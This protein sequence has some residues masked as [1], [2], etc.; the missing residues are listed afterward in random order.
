MLVRDGRN[1]DP[2]HVRDGR[3]DERRHD[4]RVAVDE[5]NRHQVSIAFAVWTSARRDASIPARNQHGDAIMKKFSVL[6]I[7]GGAALLTAVPFSLQWSQEKN[8]AVTL[9]SADA[10][11][12]QPLSAGSV[13]GVKRREGRREQRKTK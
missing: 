13:A 5:R 6:G 1:I 3:G 12:G 8:V 9:N 10:K 7:V 2:G 4:G 11:V